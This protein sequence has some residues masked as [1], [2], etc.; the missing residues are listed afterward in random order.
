MAQILFLLSQIRQKLRQYLSTSKL[1]FVSMTETPHDTKL[2]N[3]HRGE[4]VRT[5]VD[6]WDG[7]IEKLGRIIGRSRASLYRDF[8]N[9]E[10]EWT[11][12]VRIGRA[13]GHDFKAQF[14]EIAMY[15]ESLVREDAGKY[16]VKDEV[17]E[18]A[19][20]EI[21]KWKDQAYKNLAESNKWKDLYIELAISSGKLPK[22][23]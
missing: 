6:K 15:E 9:P 5:Y 8:D 10:M 16:D 2:F 18:R 22:L 7:S 11:Y 13:I 17:L 12:I 23:Q 1:S 20:R 21:D 4:V 3:L 14:P 19:I